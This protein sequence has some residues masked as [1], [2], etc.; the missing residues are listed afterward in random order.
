MAIEVKRAVSGV[1]EPTETPIASVLNLIR[2]TD[3]S[4]VQTASKRDND[5]LTAET[6]LSQLRWRMRAHRSDLRKRIKRMD[7]EHS[8]PPDYDE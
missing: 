5:L 4:E 8:E 2:E 6:G 1:V 3:V 7:S